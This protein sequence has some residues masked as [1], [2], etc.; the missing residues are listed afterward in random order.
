MLWEI[1]YPYSNNVP[2]IAVWMVITSMKEWVAYKKQ[3]LFLIVLEE[4][5]QDQSAFMVRFWQ[6]P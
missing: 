6:G 1:L 3:N 2:V 4:K 5:V